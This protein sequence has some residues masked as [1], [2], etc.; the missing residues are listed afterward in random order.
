MNFEISAEHQAL[1]DKVEAFAKE[2][3]QDD[4]VAR[5]K[6]GVFPLHFWEACA[7]QGIQG[8]ASVQGY[9][10]HLP[11]VDLLGSMMAVETLGKHCRDAGFILAL[12]AQM[13][14]VQMPILEFGTEEQKERFLKPLALGQKKGVHC[15]TEPDAGSDVFS[16]KTT[17]KKVEGGYILNG[18]KRFITLGP[19]ADIALV[20]AST[21]PELGQ[22][23][24][25][26]FIIET[27]APGFEKGPVLQKMGLRTV[28]YGELFMKD[29][30]VP[31]DQRLGKEG[32]GFSI[33]QNSLEYDRCCMLA[34]KLGA[35]E[36][37][38]EESVAY[39]KKR[40]QFGKSIGK[41]QSV[42]NRIVDMKLRL[43]T[44]RLL[45]Y[46]T[47]W[48]KSQGMPIHMEAALLKLHLS[49]SFLANSL[50][51]VRSFGGN[52]YLAEFEVER[53]VR[54]AVGGILYAGTSDIQRNIV[55]K[56][57]GL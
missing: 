13:W 8:M 31:E 1:K 24:I 40:K 34:G 19:L 47:A 37:Q 45:L 12:N 43:E 25:S 32:V 30:F 15:L 6:D 20:F 18:T 9:G 16:M 23:G 10:G 41:F 55:A 56:L 49:E 2:R 38:L 21:H 51:A 54:D 57:L 5:E 4:V 11:K 28:P 22:W 27:D 44:A 17:A 48:K 33:C 46:K 36:R 7:E 50:D 29:C 3:L 42:S 35:M 52:G 26:G 39:V 53:D 14:T